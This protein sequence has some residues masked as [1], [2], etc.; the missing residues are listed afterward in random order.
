[1]VPSGSGS[2]GSSASTLAGVN[3]FESK[4]TIQIS[5]GSLQAEK[6]EKNVCSALDDECHQSLGKYL[7]EI[8]LVH[9]KC[10]GNA[11]DEARGREK[12]LGSSKQ[13]FNYASKGGLI[14]KYE[15]GGRG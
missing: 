5:S 4:S 6:H 14:M 10:C 8:L 13:I 1:M 7:P 9:Q 12:C 3:L 11:N 2:T 15:T